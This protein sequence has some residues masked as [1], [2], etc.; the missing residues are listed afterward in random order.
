MTFDKRGLGGLPRDC[1]EF[2]RE[3]GPDF[4]DLPSKLKESDFWRDRLRLP[5]KG[6]PTREPPCTMLGS[7]EIVSSLPAFFL[8]FSNFFWQFRNCLQFACSGRRRE[9]E[10]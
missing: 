6:L 4:E 7:C 1:L 2:S 8:F 5:L 3:L 10:V 9:A